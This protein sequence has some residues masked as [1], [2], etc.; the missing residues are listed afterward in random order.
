MT[1]EP[2]PLVE[3]GPTEFQRCRLDG[4]TGAISS[5]KFQQCRGRNDEIGSTGNCN[6][7]GALVEGVEAFLYIPYPSR[8]GKGFHVEQSSYTRVRAEFLYGLSLLQRRVSERSRPRQ[9]G[10]CWLP[11]STARPAPVRPLPAA[12]VH[13]EARAWAPLRPLLRKWWR[14]RRGQRGGG[15]GHRRGGGGHGCSGGD[16]KSVV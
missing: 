15:Q 12:S 6:C 14:T 8:T 4:E 9:F 10:C 16:R 5:T 2:V 7:V 3:H 11:Q 13:S 1:V